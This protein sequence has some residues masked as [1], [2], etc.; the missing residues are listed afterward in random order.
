M[1]VNLISYKLD[2]VI[3]VSSIMMEHVQE[4]VSSETVAHQVVIDLWDLDSYS[5]PARVIL[6]YC[7]C[8]S[9]FF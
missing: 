7:V 1:I 8:Y 9:T 6:L 4:Q 5:A 2:I 3:A